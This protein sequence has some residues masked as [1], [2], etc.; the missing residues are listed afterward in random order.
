MPK[1]TPNVRKIVFLIKN[2]CMKAVPLSNGKGK[3]LV[4]GMPKS[5][6]TA[7]AQLLGAACELSVCSDPFY[8]LDKEGIE[9]RNQLFTSQITL[10]V[11]WRTY[12][13]IFKGQLIKDPNFPLL[14]D[15]LVGFLPNARYVFLVRDPRQNIRSVLNRLNLP[16]DP[17]TVDLNNMLLPSTWR[18]LLIGVD[19]FMPG[20][21][22]VERLAWRWVFSTEKLRCYREKGVWVR[23]EDFKAN[24]Q[25][26]IESIAGQLNLKVRRDIADKVDIQF[27]PAGNS[28]VKI[29]NFFSPR[30][31]RSINEIVQKQAL[32]IGYE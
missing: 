28:H 1:R 20:E 5:G 29:D 7:I 31:L 32:A 19:P 10:E 6:T 9:F 25:K 27:Q 12:R 4:C 24:R 18:N 8:M 3:V 14:M 17:S 23:Y 21:N 30:A 13:S 11:L 16:G 15:Q 2:T 22:Y 26:V